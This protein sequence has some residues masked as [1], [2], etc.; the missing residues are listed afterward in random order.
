[1]F[2]VL[3]RLGAR[4]PLNGMTGRLSGYYDLRGG[5]IVGSV[6]PELGA[7][8]K[9]A[10]EV[11]VTR[12]GKTIATFDA[13]LEPAAGRFHFEFATDGLLTGD[14]LVHERVKLKARNFRGDACE[15]KLDGATQLELI[16][17]H[18]GVPADTVVDIDFT[19]GGNA[20]PYLGKGWSGPGIF[21]RWTVDDDSWLSFDTPV[22]AGEYRLRLTMSPY[23][24]APEIDRQNMRVFVNDALLETLMLVSPGMQF[25]EFKLASEVLQRSPVTRL[26]FHHPGAVR[27]SDFEGTT[28]R[29]RLA[30]AFKRLWLVRLRPQ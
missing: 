11:V 30:F 4:H 17:D 18:L 26:W 27:P 5:R 3:K 20:E 29:R 7:T 15:L 9:G 16:R 13:D 2:D 12:R 10:M 14:D 21:E 6:I 25:N 24:R 19:R 22:P 28:D 23:L 8:I 1:M